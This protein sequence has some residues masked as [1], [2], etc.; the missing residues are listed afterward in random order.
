MLYHPWMLY[1]RTTAATSSKT[2]EACRKA[3]LS[4]PLRS[5]GRDCEAGPVWWYL[6]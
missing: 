3:A 1:H 6:R 4:V 2:F 5:V